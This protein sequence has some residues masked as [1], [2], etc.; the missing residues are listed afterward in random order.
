MGT[1]LPTSRPAPAAAALG[2]DRGT[3]VSGARQAGA[4]SLPAPRR[5]ATHAPRET[6][7]RPPADWRR[8]P[9]G[10]RCERGGVLRART[11]APRRSSS[12]QRHRPPQRPRR[13]LEHGV[14]VVG[15]EENEAPPRRHRRVAGTREVRPRGPAPAQRRRRGRV[16]TGGRGPWRR[17]AKRSGRRRASNLAHRAGRLARHRKDKS[18]NRE[19]DSADGRHGEAIVGAIQEVALVLALGPSRSPCRRTA[20]SWT[21]MPARASRTAAACPRAAPTRPPWQ[22]RKSAEPLPL[23][24]DETARS[25]GTPRARGRGTA[26]ARAGMWG[27]PQRASLHRRN[28]RPRGAPGAGEAIARPGRRSRAPGGGASLRLPR[29]RCGCAWPPGSHDAVASEQFERSLTDAHRSPRRRERAEA[30]SRPASAAEELMPGTKS[31]G[32]GRRSR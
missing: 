19:L 20:A 21:S 17:R 24:C 15:R 2:P 8:G 1:P 25:V 16:K 10:G 31:I 5:S 12:G 9:R 22:R 6:G 29:D 14:G 18:P 28:Q 26:T 32:R 30:F 3:R 7:P 23:Q 4:L 13:E 27:G 11:P